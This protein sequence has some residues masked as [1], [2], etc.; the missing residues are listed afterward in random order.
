MGSDDRDL[1]KILNIH[2]RSLE[3]LNKLARG[4]V[5]QIYSEKILVA[6]IYKEL[7]KSLESKIQDHEDQDLPNIIRFPT[8]KD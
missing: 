8:K 3:K 7:K 6:S 2:S 1:I 4:L 5:E